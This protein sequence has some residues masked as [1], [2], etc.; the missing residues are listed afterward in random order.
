M[1]IS[2][3]LP[4]YSSTIPNSFFS[5]PVELHSS[6]ITSHD[7][8]HRR[9]DALEHL[10]NELASTLAP[11]VDYRQEHDPYRMQYINH[12]RIKVVPLSTAAAIRNNLYTFDTLPF[13]ETEINAALRYTYP[14]RFI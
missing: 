14:E 6:I 5:S 9:E 4:T 2:T 13:T 3:Q 1:P 12:A 10:L 7:Y 8:N 11:F